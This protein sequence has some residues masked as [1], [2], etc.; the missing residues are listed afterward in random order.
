[1]ARVAREFDWLDSFYKKF[2][3]TRKLILKDLK[4][5]DAGKVP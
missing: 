1:M 3:S 2:A 4:E 5:L